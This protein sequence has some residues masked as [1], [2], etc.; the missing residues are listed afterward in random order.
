MTP[1]S[2]CLTHRERLQAELREISMRPWEAWDLLNAGNLLSVYDL[3]AWASRK[4][5][6]FFDSPRVG[7]FGRQPPSGDLAFL[8]RPPGAICF[9]KWAG[10][11]LLVNKFP[12]CMESVPKITWFPN[13]LRGRILMLGKWNTAS[14]LDLHSHWD[15]STSLTVHS[16]SLAWVLGPGPL[17]VGTS[18]WPGW[19]WKEASGN[20][21]PRR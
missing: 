13:P 17:G 6:E 12:T 9:Y 16:C 21:R 11:E 5:R 15:P 8:R 1:W 19:T 4:P 7:S 2:R 14:Q 18:L 10:T 3:S 20:I